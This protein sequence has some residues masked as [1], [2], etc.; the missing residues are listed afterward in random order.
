MTSSSAEV[1]RV[2]RQSAIVCCMAALA[3][4]AIVSSVHELGTFSVESDFYAS[5]AVQAKR[6]LAGQPYTYRFHPPG[7][8]LLLAGV[9]RLVHGDLFLA[10]KLMTAAS[11]ALLGWVSYLLLRRLWGP[12]VALVAL[13]LLLLRLLPFSFLAATD[14]VFAL[15]VL[16]PVW[17]LFR[18]RPARLTC[19]LAGVLVG[20]AYLIRSNAIF[21]A[22]A[23]P[24]VWLAVDVFDQPL[25]L[26]A[27]QAALVVA[28]WLVCVT[29]WLV[30][31]W[32]LNGSPFASE[33]HLH[34]AS[35]F[36]GKGR[37]ELGVT[38]REAGQTGRFKGA[39]DVWRY[40]PL[41]LTRQ[42]AAS[43]LC[44]YP[45]RM[46]TSILQWPTLLAAIAGLALFLRRRRRKQLAVALVFAAGYLILGL[47]EFQVRY[48]VFLFPLLFGVAA[49]GLW[50]RP[51]RR[52]RLAGVS[53]SVLATVACALVLG[54]HSVSAG[55]RTVYSEP[56]YLLP[57]ADMLRTRATPDNIL[58]AQKPHLAYLAGMQW[59]FVLGHT[60]QEFLD[61]ARSL[62]AR[63]IE[64]S[65]LEASNWPGL[66]CLKDPAA[67]PKEFTAIY[68]D[69]AHSHTVL[70]EL[71]APEEV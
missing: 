60:P 30:V 37:D 71:H 63:Y 62:G 8:S 4:G 51:L 57:M 61:G 44:R 20:A 39:L 1:S 29:P 56:R 66:S 52:V 40:D 49:C 53:L 26:R 25:L 54:A 14:V 48:Y 3:F 50:S 46:A 33:N 13:M 45:R 69:A 38:L 55:R 70:Y 41:R 17:V 28:G 19:F 47:V 23:A 36:Y 22:V 15:S 21:L 10:S 5:F 31:N 2:C 24:L 34:L 16:V 11:T 59:D 42:Y 7:Y 27:Q 43:L 6:L 32:R 35:H 9:S 12:L 64:Y 18:R 65:D 68:Q 58:V 67:L